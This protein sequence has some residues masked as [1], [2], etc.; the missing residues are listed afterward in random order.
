MNRIKRRSSGAGPTE[1]QVQAAYIKIV[2]LHQKRYPELGLLLAVPSGGNRN[3]ITGALLKAEGAI[4]GVPDILWPLQ[5][6]AYNGLAL[7]FKRPK[8][9]GKASTEQQVFMALLT[10]HGWRCEVVYD[11]LMA[12]EHTQCHLFN[13]MLSAPF[14][15][16]DA[17]VE[18][19]RSVGI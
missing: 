16:R 13:Q 9:K 18:D 12:W 6:G 7:E 1:H 17:L 10:Q 2:R 5:R 8:P 15:W 14:A 19:V 3:V 11:A 4:K